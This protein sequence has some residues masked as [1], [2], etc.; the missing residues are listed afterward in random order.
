M[1]DISLRTIKTYG[2]PAEAALARARLHEAGIS[3]FLQGEQTGTTLWYV[4]T[5]LGGVKLQV[6]ENEVPRA[7]EVLAERE[8]SKA[9]SWT[10]GECG[11][12]VDAGFDIC[13][14]CGATVEARTQDPPVAAATSKEGDHV[15]PDD[16]PQTED[17]PRDDA[18]ELLRRAW[19]ASII[20]LF[21][22]PGILNLYAASLLAHYLG[23]Q[24]ER[25]IAASP[26]VTAAF[27]ANMLVV[28]GM[29][30]LLL[31]VLSG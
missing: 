1:G 23:I 3:A 9:V 31:S 20:G 22:C 26:R 19:R 24:R 7:M 17:A 30:A 28:L 29:G 4:G 10:C 8:E 6:P 18:E 12:H 11:A 5:A 16:V 27:W 15:L 14:S 21:L 13:W 2:S 25:G